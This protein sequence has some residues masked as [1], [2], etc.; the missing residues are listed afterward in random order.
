M[1]KVFV[2]MQDMER[3]VR[4]QVNKKLSGMR[5]KIRRM[6]TEEF[7]RENY[8]HQDAYRFLKDLNSQLELT[9]LRLK[10]LE[11]IALNL[12]KKISNMSKKSNKKNDS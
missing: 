11:L 4:K 2:S 8:N 7:D 5:F 9:K 12:D 3:E 1:V 10:D 6:V